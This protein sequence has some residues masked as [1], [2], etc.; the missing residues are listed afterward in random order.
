[1]CS[2][3]PV[4]GVFVCVS[5][6]CMPTASVICDLLLWGPLSALGRRPAAPTVP[7]ISGRLLALVS[8]MAQ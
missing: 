8:R 5:D 2:N 1:M 3:S 7:L 6:I 4:S